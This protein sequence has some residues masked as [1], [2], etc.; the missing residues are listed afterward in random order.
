[1]STF[2]FATMMT[3]MHHLF[4]MFISDKCIC[5]VFLCINEKHIY[6]FQIVVDEAPQRLSFQSF[7]V[8]WFYSCHWFRS[9]SSLS[10]RALVLTRLWV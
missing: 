9:T 1:M 6:G 5:P 4:F 7:G 10:C 8:R 3:N 2:F